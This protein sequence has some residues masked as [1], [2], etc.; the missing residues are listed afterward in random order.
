[1]FLT[2]V[3]IDRVAS[4]QLDKGFLKNEVIRSNSIVLNTNGYYEMPPTEFA[5]L[6]SCGLNINQLPGA[7]S[8]ADLG[9]NIP[10]IVP[11]MQS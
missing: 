9:R 3:D 7:K 2:L 5:I 4:R 1:M 6:S 11:K 10:L 8:D